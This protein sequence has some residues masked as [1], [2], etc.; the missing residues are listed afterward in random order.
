MAYLNPLPILYLGSRGQNK[1]TLIGYLSD[2]LLLFAQQ[3]LPS[4]TYISWA[5]KLAHLSF[6]LTE[7]HAGARLPPD[8]PLLGLLCAR[9][10]TIPPAREVPA[11][12]ATSLAPARW[13]SLSLAR[14]PSLAGVPRDTHGRGYQPRHDGQPPCASA[15]NP[16]AP[17]W[18]ALAARWPPGAIPCRSSPRVTP[19]LGTMAECPNSASIGMHDSCRTSTSLR[20]PVPCSSP[21]V[22][23]SSM[24]KKIEERMTHGTR[25]SFS[26]RMG[27]GSLFYCWNRKQNLG[28]RKIGGYL[29]RHLG[30]LI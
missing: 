1:P 10:T 28:S 24:E 4:T 5:N 13:P 3:I 9:S 18:P 15:V 17:P 27:L 22:T 7:P 14:R 8:P 12:S 21:P 16:N 29:N 2:Y 6:P 23:T 30:S 20:Q 11:S 25:M 19:P 26:G